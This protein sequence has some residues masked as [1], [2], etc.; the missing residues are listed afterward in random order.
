MKKLAIVFSLMLSVSLYAQ[1]PTLIEVSAENWEA[2][3][4]GDFKNVLNY[5]APAPVGLGVDTLLLTSSGFNYT[6]KDT[7]PLMIKYPVVI[8]AAPGL[9]EKPIFSVPNTG[10]LDG[11]SSSSMEIFRI[12]NTVEFHGVAFMGNLNNDQTGSKYGLRFGDWT[13]KVSGV[14]T[15]V[16]KGSNII[17]DDCDFIN[18]HS[19][20]DPDAQ[21]NALYFMRDDLFLNEDYLR[22]GTVR[23]ENCLFKDVGD[24][25]IRIAE[26]QKYGTDLTVG[27]NAFDTLI[28]RNTTFDDIDAECIRFYGDKDTSHAGPTFEDGFALIEHCTSVNSSPRFLYGQNYRRTIVRDILIANGRP[29]GPARGDR[30]D[31]AIQAQLSGSEVSHIDTFSLVFPSYYSPR[32]GCTKGGDVDEATVYAYDPGF[33]DAANG[34]YTLLSSSPLYHLSSD[35]TAIGDLRWATNTPDPWVNGV[36]SDRS[37]PDM[38]MLKQNYPNPFNPLTTISFTLNRADFTTLTLYDLL[39]NR[40]AT[41]VNRFMEAGS[42]SVTIDASLLPSGVYFYELRQGAMHDM[43][44]MILMK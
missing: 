14:T 4:Q 32:I 34:D 29:A 18:F 17:L 16:K 21:G 36:K 8:M 44:K 42:H 6:T 30:N 5:T 41:E 20:G 9:A 28:V 11:T 10:F 31:Y 1:A 23:I 7:L 39:G 37:I 33:T 40:I 27:T 2:Y 12:M 13:D 25:A 24:E 3:F 22:A 38:F 26:N 35:G 15:K 43:K 19:A